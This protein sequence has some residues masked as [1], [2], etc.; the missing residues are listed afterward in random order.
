MLTQHII[1][2]LFAYSIISHIGS[3]LLALSINSAES[4]QSYLFYILQYTLSNLN[5]F[6]ILVT[7]GFSLFI[8]VYNKK[9]ETEQ[10]IDKNNW[11]IQLINQI[12]GYFYIN[13]LRDLILSITTFSFIGYFYIN[14]LRDLI[15]SITI[16]SFIGIPPLIGFFAKQMVLSAAL[17]SGYIFMALIAIITSVIGAGYYLNV[18]KNIFF[19]KTDYNKS[20]AVDVI[21]I[22]GYIFINNVYKKIKLNPEDII[23]SSSLPSIISILTLLLILFIYICQE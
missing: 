17:D 7:I 3:T 9:D 18:I 2:R 1:K 14:P 23:I 15:L 21:S 11:P 8:Y 6:I 10:L 19:Y 22:T 12:K 20:P 16:F 5:G 13:P 4:I